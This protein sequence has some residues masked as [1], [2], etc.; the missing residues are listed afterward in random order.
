MDRSLL[1][2]QS[3]LFDEAEAF[4]RSLPTT[5]RTLFNIGFYVAR[6]GHWRAAMEMMNH[7]RFARV[8]GSPPITGRIWMFEKLDGKTVLLRGEGGFGDE[9]NNVR[10]AK[11]LSSLGATV[12]VSACGS[13]LPV[14]ATAPGVS[15]AVTHGNEG[16]YD[17]WIPALSGPYFFDF[18][19]KPFLKAPFSQAP[20]LG[21]GL[22][23]GIRWAGNPQF[24]HEQQRR[25]PIE[26]LLELRNIQGVTVTSFQRDHSLINLPE[27]ILQADMVDWGDTAAQ[28]AEM[29]IFITSC[30]SVAHLA[31]A[32]GIPTWIVVP[33][34]PYYTWAMPGEK[35][36]WYD[37]VT[38]Y[39]QE[40]DWPFEKLRADLEAFV[41]DR[42]QKNVA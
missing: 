34:L 16:K 36:P 14:L 6:R 10:W 2:A 32:M 13:L 20:R 3:G 11:Q 27:G 15:V 38:L 26:P 33:R 17:Y 28:L 9:I 23:V 31:A 5:P 40:K 29:D 8:F 18:D 1:L 37:S 39:R 25:F 21:C 24:E 35:T 7:G 42:K 12:K 41:E 30:T 19:G 4:L 22:N